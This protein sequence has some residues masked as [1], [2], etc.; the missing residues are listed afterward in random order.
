ME[1]RKKTIDYICE[2]YTKFR[3]LE[4]FKDFLRSYPELSTEI[5]FYL[6]EHKLN[7][8]DMFIKETV[9]LMLTLT[10]LSSSC[11]LFAIF[12]RR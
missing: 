6:I 3:Q 10:V 5:S 9:E 8:R 1:L 4:E 12:L 11:F 7:S 2:N